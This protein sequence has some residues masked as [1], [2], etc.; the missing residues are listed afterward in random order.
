MHAPRVSELVVVTKLLEE[1]SKLLFLSVRGC[2]AVEVQNVVERTFGRDRE[3]GV[4]AVLLAA[5]T[6]LLLGVDAAVVI[7]LVL[8]K[9]L[10]NVSGEQLHLFGRGLRRLGARALRTHADGIAELRVHCARW[11]QATRV[12][13]RRLHL[14]VEHPLLVWLARRECR[15]QA[16]CIETRCCEMKSR[17][18]ALQVA[19][20][21]THGSPARHVRHGVAFS[22]VAK[23]LVRCLRHLAFG[24]MEQIRAGNT[25]ES[26]R[27]DIGLV[28]PR[29]A[30]TVLRTVQLVSLNGSSSTTYGT[31]P[32]PIEMSQCA[33]RPQ[34]SRI[35]AFVCSVKKMFRSRAESTILS[36]NS[37]FM[38]SRAR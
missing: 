21:H 5:G 19:V 12:L 36:R 20:A 37:S 10:Q 13:A 6:P 34:P 38:S 24:V 31:P 28:R 8:H 32:L 30:P 14:A 2:A 23:E 16:A 25:V 18:L 1:R 33:I 22:S 29:H 4:R 27:D 15:Q 7:E 17:N 35:S 3:H 9:V 26:H 11:R